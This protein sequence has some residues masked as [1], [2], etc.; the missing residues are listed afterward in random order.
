MDDQAE[1]LRVRLKQQEANIQTRTI[2]VVSGKG[3]VGKSNFSLNFAISLAKKGHSV[4]LFD[5]DIGMGNIDILLGL[6]S[7]YSIA[8]F[9][10]NTVSLNSVITEIPGS[11]H[12]I[13]GGTGFSQL[14]KINKE[15]FQSFTDQFTRLLVNYEYVI[16]DM[17]AGINENSLR[18]ILSVDEVIV[19]TTPEPTSITDS[20]AAMKYITLKSRNLPF[21]MI[22]NRTHSEKEGIATFNRI[23]Q[24][25]KQFLEKTVFL[26]GVLPDDQNISKAVRRQTPFI[27]LNEKSPASKAIIEITEKFCQREFNEL[28]QPSKTNFV[29]RFKRFLFEKVVRPLEKKEAGKKTISLEEK[30]SKMELSSKDLSIN[31]NEMKKR[32]ILIGTSTGGPNALQV[33]LTKLP[34]DI[35]APILIVQ[36]MPS[37][38][39][40]SLANRI[41]S[42]A[43]I[44]VK[45]AE[46][47]ETL[48]NGTAYIAPGG[49]H[50]RVKASGEKLIVQLD[51]ANDNC[52]Y[53]PS[54]DVMFESAS[55]LNRY[56]K[57]AVIMTGM[58]SDGTK[59]LILLKNNGLVKAIAQSEETCIVFGMPRAAIATE[60]IDDIVNVESIAETILKYV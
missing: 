53:C 22:I 15:S 37:G 26:L 16:L 6:S 47:G 30:Y 4:L 2:A 31:W 42:L 43:E 18:F 24:V 54:V 51:R 48:Q 38:F 19:I 60:L 40:N 44:E 20:Y 34:K 1:S 27:Q 57:I 45:E 32:I 17:G 36:H 55:G 35:P 29:A 41:N 9:F 11:I 33:V 52:I 13:S 14:T 3:G 10:T 59:G 5:M 58:G 25:L 23:S 8:D 56:G 21:Y 39:T 46:N 50:L 12:Y 7:T 28:S 49:C